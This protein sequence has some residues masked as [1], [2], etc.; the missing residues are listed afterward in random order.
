MFSEELHGDLTVINK[1]GRPID[2]YFVDESE[3]ADEIL[4][5]HTSIPLSNQYS[6]QIRAYDT[7]K[8]F[9]N[10][11]SPGYSDP[12]SFGYFTKGPRDEY[13][14]NC[15]LNYTMIVFNFFNILVTVF[16]DEVNNAFTFK[17]ETDLDKFKNNLIQRLDTCQQ[18]E[19]NIPS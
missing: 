19:G 2:V 6:F 8:F 3:N 11:S 13:G 14:I 9:V 16:F 12:P 18:Q 7:N 17:F 15:E 1:S 4:T 5:K 10:N